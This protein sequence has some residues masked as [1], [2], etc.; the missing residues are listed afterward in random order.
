MALLSPLIENAASGS[1]RWEAYL[2]LSRAYAIQGR[3]ADSSTALAAA[4]KEA[5]LAPVPADAIAVTAMDVAVPVAISRPAWNVPLP[6]P[7]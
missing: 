5:P 1:S 3:L 2:L 7:K 4:W 6:F